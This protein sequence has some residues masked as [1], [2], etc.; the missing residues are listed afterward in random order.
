[1]L[2]AIMGWKELKYVSFATKTKPNHG[3]I[4]LLLDAASD[5]RHKNMN[6][7]IFKGYLHDLQ[8]TIANLWRITLQA[9][10]YYRD[11]A[12]FK[13]TRHAMWI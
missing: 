11:I 3:V 10:A 7:S 13:A 8:E 5:A 1:M 12:N 6:T 9:V 2:I 4:Y